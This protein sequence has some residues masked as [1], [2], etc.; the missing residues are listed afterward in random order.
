MANRYTIE[1]PFVKKLA[2]AAWGV[3]NHDNDYESGSEYDTAN[4]KRLREKIVEVL[5]HGQIRE[6][7]S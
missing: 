5:N 1:S 7:G 2:A 6:T 4:W 3:L